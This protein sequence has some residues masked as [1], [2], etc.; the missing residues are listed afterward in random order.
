MRS[1]RVV[2]F[3]TGLF[4]GL[5]IGVAGGGWLAEAHADPAP[6]ITIDQLRSIVTGVDPAEDDPAFDCRIHGNRICGPGNAQGV[7][8]GQYRS[9][10]ATT[11]TELMLAVR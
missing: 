6:S 2:A 10:E 5:A 11:F 4:V 3:S 1:N 9:S 7:P 8:P